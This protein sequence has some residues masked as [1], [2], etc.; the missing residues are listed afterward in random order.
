MQER[1]LAHNLNIESM[2]IHP[3]TWGVETIKKMRTIKFIRLFFKMLGTPAWY[4]GIDHPTFWQRI[5]WR[6]TVAGMFS[7]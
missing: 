2:L 6:T 1:S 7:A 4:Q 5:T 3:R